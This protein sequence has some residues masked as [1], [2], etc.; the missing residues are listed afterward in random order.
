MAMIRTF[1]CFELPEHVKNTLDELQS[2]LKRYGRGVRWVRPQGIHLTLKFL[3]DVEANLIDRIG[4]GVKRASNGMSPID[5]RL[6][7]AGA[8][9]NFKR[10]RVFWVGI[11]EPSGRLP[12]LY[13]AIEDAMA[14]LGFAKEQ[15]PFSPHLTI[16]RV[17]SHDGLNAVIEALKDVKLSPM[18]F[19]AGR[20]VVMQSQLRP[21]G[22]VYT[23]LKI[24]EL[25]S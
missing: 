22:A 6:Q 13:A 2:E 5:I 15:R 25:G 11:D 7:Q 1:I 14:G 24:I 17:K 10:P 18:K 9:P 21:G 12:G 4:D 8:F 3:G 23:P 16:G 19:T 20:V